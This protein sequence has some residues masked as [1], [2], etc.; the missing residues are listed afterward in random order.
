MR[1]SKTMMRMLFM[2]SVSIWGAI[3]LTLGC[4]D[5]VES[6]VS[7]DKSSS[8]VHIVNADAVHHRNPIGESVVSEPQGE[9]ERLRMPSPP[10]LN[11]GWIRYD[12]MKH[13][14]L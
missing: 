7:Q 1:K 2:R 13:I 9:S 4:I 10:L 8:S 5:K 6:L 3:I 11:K 12:Y 14:M